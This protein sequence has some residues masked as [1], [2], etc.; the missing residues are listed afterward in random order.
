MEVVTIKKEY[1]VERGYPFYEQHM[2]AVM[3][4]VSSPALP[5][6][7]GNALSFDYPVRYK[8][9]EGFNPDWWNDEEGPSEERF[10]TV[11]GAA[12]KLEEEGVK[13]V[14]FG[15]GFTGI[16]Q[17][18]LADNLHIPV[19]GSPLVMAGLI[20][21]L[22]GKSKKIGILTINSSE[23]TEELLEAVGVDEN[24]NYV[25]DEMKDAPEFRAVYCGGGKKDLD[26]EA[27]RAE[28]V[29]NAQRMK[30]ENPDI[31]AFLIEFRTICPFTADIVAHTGVPTFDAITLANFVHQATNPK[32][33]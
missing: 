5:G 20:Q 27:F 10:Q 2:G 4:P 19:F 22:I 1:F 3:L 16:Y 33:Y 25:I 14:T 12:K 18:R 13:A 30:K 29:A 11:L 17:D 21:K 9:L 26:V 15:C 7:I 32:G 6:N 23:L 28:T 31:G 24:I 8:A